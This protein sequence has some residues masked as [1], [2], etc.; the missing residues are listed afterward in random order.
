LNLDRTPSAHVEPL[1]RYLQRTGR[2]TEV[3]FVPYEFQRGGNQMLRIVRSIT[4]DSV[5]GADEC[6][7][8]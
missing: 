2:S 3:R 8:R 5:T 4:R 1:R 6:S 7:L